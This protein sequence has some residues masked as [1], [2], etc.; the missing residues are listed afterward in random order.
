ML[1]GPS[2]R[3]DQVQFYICTLGA[4][5]GPVSPHAMQ[6]CDR[7]PKGVTLRSML[8]YLQGGNIPSL[9]QANE[10]SGIAGRTLQGDM[11]S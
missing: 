11:D 7:V 3:A 10:V 6:V 9:A 5:F 1:A 4:D 8:A 2:S